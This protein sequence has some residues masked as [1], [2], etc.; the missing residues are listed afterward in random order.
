[1]R[2][3]FFFAEK[4]RKMAFLVKLTSFWAKKIGKTKK[5]KN[6]PREK[7]YLMGNFNFTN[8]GVNLTI[9]EEEDSFFAFFAFFAKNRN[10]FQFFVIPGRKI[11]FFWKKNFHAKFCGIESR[12]TKFQGN[13]TR[14]SHFIDIQRCHRDPKFKPPEPIFPYVLIQN[15]ENT[16]IAVKSRKII[17][18]AQIKSNLH[19]F[20]Y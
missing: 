11:H 12:Y 3:L 7:F 18:F 14:N 20:L 5:F 19:Y 4:S 9:F 2:N 13:P 10:F 1:M 8:F 6:P 16:K 17:V 15:V